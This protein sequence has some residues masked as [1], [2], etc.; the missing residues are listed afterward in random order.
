MTLNELSPVRLSHQQITDHHFENPEDVVSWMG[1]MQAQDFNMAKWAVALRLPSATH[2]I[3]QNAFDKG[4]IIR[5]HAMRPTWHF[6]SRKD[7]SWM[8][9]LTAPQIRTSARSRHKELELTPVI[10]KKSLKALEKI[11][12]GVSHMTRDELV[13]ALEKNRIVTGGQR[14]AHILLWA[15]LEKI[16]CSGPT[17]GKKNTYALFQKRVKDE[18]TLT[19]DEA[20]MNLAMRHFQSHGPATL[21]DFV[22]W[23]FLP[24]ADARKAI[25]FIR[26]DFTSEK[27]GSQTYWF[28]DWKLSKA[29]VERLHLLP[30]FDEYIIGYKD[31]SACLPAKHKSTVISINGIFWPVIVLDGIVI[32][33]WKKT[34]AKDRVKI[35]FKFFRG[36]NVKK[37][38][39]L[40][41][42]L[43]E[44]G[45]RSAIFFVNDSG[46]KP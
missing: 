1:A 38:K 25:E 15:E 20:L 28:K 45:K 16:I 27:L 3:I 37:D 11:L 30:A 21:Q 19:R 5:T 40:R 41:D 46:V 24:I 12:A 10:L 2:A 29:Q 14:A 39:Q 4:E 7:V 42:K 9:D 6:I 35:E 13:A 34:R 22:N 32:G 18:I 17:V 43:D 23:S 8:L 33:L 36:A 44:A 26:N 31:R